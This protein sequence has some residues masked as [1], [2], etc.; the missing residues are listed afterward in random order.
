[1]SLRL[2]L[3]ILKKEK[4]RASAGN[5]ILDRPAHINKIKP[6]PIYITA[7][8]CGLLRVYGFGKLVAK[9]Y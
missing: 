5:Q 3:D 6:F 9:S 2:G 7:Q 8:N 1:M 4:S